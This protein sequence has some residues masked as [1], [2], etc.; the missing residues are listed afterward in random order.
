MKKFLS[1]TLTLVLVLSFFTPLAYAAD[2]YTNQDI[3]YL[4]NEEQI[5]D[6][7]L[8]IIEKVE[9]ANK[10]IQIKIDKAVKRADYLMKVYADYPRILDRKLDRLAKNLVDETN[11]IARKTIEE[12]A[13]A[14]VEVQC[15]LVEVKLGYKTVWVDPMEVTGW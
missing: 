3:M 9:E 15:T 1:F 13:E 5:D 12:A 6:D 10:E 4:S 11:E 14:G 2:D 8:E 7:V